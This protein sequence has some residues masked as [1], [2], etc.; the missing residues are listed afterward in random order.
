MVAF[1]FAIALPDHPAVFAG[2][3]PHLGAEEI[4]AVGTDKP[5]REDTV[6]AV[7]VAQCLAAGHLQ[8]NDLPLVRRDDRL[9]ALLDILLRG[10]ALIRFLA[11]RQEISRNFLL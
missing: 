6:P 8:L 10:L 2:R 3:V 11:F 1:E 5:R 7:F 9:M 4:A